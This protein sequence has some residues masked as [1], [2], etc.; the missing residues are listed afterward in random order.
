MNPAAVLLL[1]FAI[2]A[3]MAVAWY[4]AKSS[5]PAASAPAPAPAPAPLPAPTPSPAPAPLPPV[6]APTP[7]PT[8]Q[9]PKMR[10][11][12]GG[13][14]CPAGWEDRGM[15][16]II[17]IN[18][19]YS[20]SPLAPGGGFNSD[21][22]WTHGRICYGDKNKGV[23]GLYKFGTAPSNYPTVG[24]I[25]HNSV[26]GQTPFAQ[27]G[28]FN[29]GWTWTHPVLEDASSPGGYY[30]DVTGGGVGPA[31]LIMSNGDLNTKNKFPVGG[32]FNDGWTWV[33]PNLVPDV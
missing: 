13:P 14:N 30:V 7:P 28:A 19:Q 33:H 32:G 15:A 3:L 10:Y 29:D 4:V 11:Y 31:G 25:L 12:L 21:W 24:V 6:P 27:G 16:G 5:Q 20:K 1:V 9:P 18:S 23:A 2:V 22:T 8:P 26:Y 17:A